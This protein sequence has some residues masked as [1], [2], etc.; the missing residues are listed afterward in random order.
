LG[1]G[2]AALALHA[3]VLCLVRHHQ[4]DGLLPGARRLGLIAR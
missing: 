1:R 4:R 2:R 3:Q